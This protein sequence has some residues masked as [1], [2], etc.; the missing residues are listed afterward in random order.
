MGKCWMDQAVCH[1][2]LC[3]HLVFWHL[4]FF[5]SK[6]MKINALVLLCMAWAPARASFEQG[7]EEASLLQVNK[8]D[9]SSDIANK[10]V[11]AT[12]TDESLMA[13]SCGNADIYACI[14]GEVEGCESHY[15]MRDYHCTPKTREVCEGKSQDQCLATSWCSPESHYTSTDYSKYK[16]ESLWEYWCCDLLINSACRYNL[17]PIG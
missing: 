5:A 3:A 13:E 12:V 4:S 11:T 1:C 10:K 9:H 17:R 6:T 2:L 15:F 7:N 8:V 14:K 16:D